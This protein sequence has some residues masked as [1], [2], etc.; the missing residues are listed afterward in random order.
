MESKT[1]KIQSSYY[2]YVCRKARALY[3]INPI[4]KELKRIKIII[5]IH[6][7]IHQDHLKIGTIIIIIEN[8]KIISAILSRIAPVSLIYLNFLAIYPSNTSL[9]P[10][11]V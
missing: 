3:F 5:P 9:N 6:T 7:N 8:I 10:Q 4:N 1:I 2:L 11:I